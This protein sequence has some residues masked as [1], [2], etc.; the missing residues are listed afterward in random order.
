MI[1]RLLHEPGEGNRAMG[2]DFG[3]NTFDQS[4]IADAHL[5]ISLSR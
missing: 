5:I 4:V 3:T 2:F 1:K